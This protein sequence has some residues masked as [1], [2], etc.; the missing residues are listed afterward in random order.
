MLSDR[1]HFFTFKSDIRTVSL[2]LLSLVGSRFEMKTTLSSTIRDGLVIVSWSLSN[3]EMETVSQRRTRL[4][5]SST[6][7]FI[8]LR[9]SSVGASRQAKR[10]A[11]GFPF[12]GH[13]T[14]VYILDA[15]VLL[16]LSTLSGIEC[17]TISAIDSYENTSK[18]SDAAK[19][20]DGVLI[21]YFSP[22]K[23][24]LSFVVNMQASVTSQALCYIA[25]SYT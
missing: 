20:L 3:S 13:S 19:I 18:E 12:E 5:L 9:A 10:M 21:R 16:F 6:T 24:V 1:G 4:V 14:L 2:G 25:L 22:F 15:W 23:L 7:S 8:Y 11:F 17:P